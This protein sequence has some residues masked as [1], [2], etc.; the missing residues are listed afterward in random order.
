MGRI[1]PLLSKRNVYAADGANMLSPAVAGARPLVYVPNSVSDTVDVVDPKTY[2]IVAHFPVGGLPQHVVPSWDLKTLYVTNDT[3]NSLTPIDPTHRPPEGPADPR[4]RPLQHVLHPRRPLRDR[5]RRAAAPARLPRRAHLR[6]PPLG[7]GALLGC[8]PHGLHRRRPLR[9]R[10]L[11]VLG[12]D[13]EDR[14][15]PR[16]GREDDRAPPRRDAAGRQALPRRQGLLRRRHV[17]GRGLGD[18]RQ[19]DPQARL[20]AHRAR[21]ARPLPEP[22]R[23]GTST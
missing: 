1:P 4:R 3:G 22:R 2:K 16:A 14:R 7:H 15:R 19:R 11:R 17:V 8:R 13:A 23:A 12:A 10:E 21:R 18:R 9:A 20:H 5:R 6:A